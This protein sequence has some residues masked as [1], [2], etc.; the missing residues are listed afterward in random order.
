MAILRIQ[1][2][3]V[4]GQVGDMYTFV[5]GVPSMPAHTAKVTTWRSGKCHMGSGGASAGHEELGAPISSPD[6]Y[7]QGTRH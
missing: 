4:K 3:P 2:T 6:T 1:Q 7:P 5:C